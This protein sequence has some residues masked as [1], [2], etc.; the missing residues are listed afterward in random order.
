MNRRDA[1]AAAGGA[2]LAPLTQRVQHTTQKQ[3]SE[4][5]T[6]ESR[7]LSLRRIKCVRDE[8]ERETAAGALPAVRGMDLEDLINGFAC[9]FEKKKKRR[10]IVLL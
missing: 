3:R 1:E 6:S 8:H 5:A 10:K 7:D 4:A 9:R 2:P